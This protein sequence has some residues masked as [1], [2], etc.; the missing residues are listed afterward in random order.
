MQ[1]I[2]VEHLYFEIHFIAPKIIL[3]IVSLARPILINVLHAFGAFSF[4]LSY[5]A[6]HLQQNFS[7]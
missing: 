7:I 5:G 4:S 2:T 1:V 3:T 6:T